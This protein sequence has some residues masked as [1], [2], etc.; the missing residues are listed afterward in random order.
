M[1]FLKGCFEAVFLLG[2]NWVLAAKQRKRTKVRK[3]YEVRV[4]RITKNNVFQDVS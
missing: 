4:F 2:C 1:K 3:L